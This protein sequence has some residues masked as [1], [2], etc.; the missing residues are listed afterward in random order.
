M[1]AH[2]GIPWHMVLEAGAQVSR[3]VGKGTENAID[4]R[5]DAMG[6][7]IV[8]PFLATLVLALVPLAQAQQTKIYRIGVILEGGPYHAAVD[9][10]K[11]GLNELGFGEGKQYVLEIRDLKGDRR[12]AEAAARSLEGERVDLIYTLATSVTTLVKRATT[13]VPIVFTVGNDPVVAGLVESFARPGGRLTGVYRQDTEV[14]AKRLEI[15]KAIFPDLH[16]VVMFYDPSNVTAVAGA[17]SVREAARQ[18][19]VEFVER[20]VASVEELRLGFQALR[21]REVDAFLYSSDGMVISQAQFI[22]DMARTKRLPTMSPYPDL[23]AQGALAGYGV[24]YREAGRASAKYVHRVLTGTSPQDLPVELLSRM[25]LAVNLKT[26]RELGITIPQSVLL[27]A[28]AV[29]Q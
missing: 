1:N 11:D 20:H 21:A 23:V 26:A 6:K 27:R 7:K 12:A 2:R 8:V 9:G 29:I 14:I 25:Q 4:R 13:E 24:S 15:L 10:L 16:R 28:D 5:E 18:L 3:A 17:K 19:H 22:I